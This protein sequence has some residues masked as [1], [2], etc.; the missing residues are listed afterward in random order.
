[1]KIAPQIV[2]RGLQRSDAVEAA[3]R[4][5]VN[6]LEQ[7]CGDIMSCRVEI[8]ELEKHKRQGQPFGVRIHV[9]LPKHELTV[10]R[11]ENED[12]YV[13]LRDAFD[14]MKRQIED[15]V[16]RIR[17]QEKL[18]PGTLH[19]EVVRLVPEERHGFIRTPDGDEYYFG[20]DNVVGVPFEHVQAGAQ[21]QFIPELAGQ[22]KQAKR[23][24]L[25]KHE[26]D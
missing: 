26:F 10:D 6:K 25:G 18:H 9:K 20:A 23:V 22:G 1:M 3:A 8:D 24:S 12:V 7:F 14:D 15:A 13:A 4:A 17:G 21:V 19:G 11:V 16:R 2:F 5:K